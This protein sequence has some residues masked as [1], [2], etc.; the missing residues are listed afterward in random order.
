MSAHKMT[1]SE[2]SGGKPQ[3]AWLVMAVLI[4]WAGCSVAAD[5]IPDLTGTWKGSAQTVV[6]GQLIHAKPTTK[7]NSPL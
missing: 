7:P 3:I 5:P 1:D 2:I 4:S 6:V